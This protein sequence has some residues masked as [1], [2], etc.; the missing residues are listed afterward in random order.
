MSVRQGILII[1]HGSREEAANAMLESIAAMVR[2]RV[3]DAVVRTAHLEIAE[4]TIE[5]G[6]AACVRAGATDIVAA[7]YF[8]VRGRHVR[9]DVPEQVDAAAAGYPEATVRIAEPLGPHRLLAQ[10]VIERSGLDPD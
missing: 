1:D 8:L 9:V 10:L 5:E 7:P 6:L 3:P 2:E 4:P